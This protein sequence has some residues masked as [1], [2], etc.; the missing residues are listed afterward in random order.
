MAYLGIQNPVVASALHQFSEDYI[1]M[2]LV[3]VTGIQP[4]DDPRRIFVFDRANELAAVMKNVALFL[5]VQV[6]N[7]KILLKKREEE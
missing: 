7:L 5:T 6:N 4:E 3:M 1:S 2:I